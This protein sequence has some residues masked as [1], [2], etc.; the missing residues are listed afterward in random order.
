MNQQE[1]AKKKKERKR[2]TNLAIIGPT[3]WQER[4]EVCIRVW[5]VAL[6]WGFPTLTYIIVGS[7]WELSRLICNFK[8]GR[9]EDTLSSESKMV[10]YYEHIVQPQ[11]QNVMFSGYS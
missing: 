6:L 7:Y 10:L 5:Y 4:L 9:S 2:N 8:C 1:V 11:L 3:N